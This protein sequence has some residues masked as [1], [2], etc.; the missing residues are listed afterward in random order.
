MKK[1][2]V[3]GVILIAAVAFSALEGSAVAAEWL[4]D[5]KAITTATAAKTEGK[6]AL[7]ADGLS[8]GI[9]CTVVATGTVGPGPADEV[10]S[11]TFSGCVKLG[12][13]TSVDAVAAVNLPWKTEVLGEGVKFF[14]DLTPGPGGGV[15]GYLIECLV[16]F[17]LAD[18]VCSKAESKVELANLATD[19][20]D[21]FNT[22]E[23]A[24]CT[25]GGPG[26]AHGTQLTTV[27]GHTLQVS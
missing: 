11:V 20:E 19:V 2:H 23:E 5:G 7:E 15:P 22:E 18:N 25:T 4:L 24:A 1:L 17:I 27:E 6:V 12:N 14:D 16:G 3:I 9:E 8:A 13:C 10:K 21:L 26:L